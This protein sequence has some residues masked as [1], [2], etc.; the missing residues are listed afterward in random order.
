M[1]SKKSHLKLYADECFPIPSVTYLKSLGFSIIHAYD[2]KLVK[3]S[4]RLHLKTSRKLNRVLITLDRDFIYYEQ[5][6][7]IEHPGVIVISVGSTTTVSVNK[8]CKKLLKT[9]GDDYVKASLVRVTN[10]KIIKKKKDKV[11]EQNY[12]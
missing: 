8:V 2:L 4:D 5:A 11:H 6:S 9:I 3:K 1:P 12:R 10:T 7:L